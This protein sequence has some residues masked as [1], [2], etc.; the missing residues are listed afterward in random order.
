[1]QQRTWMAGLLAILAGCA[2]P[3]SPVPVRGE[4][5]H[6]DGRWVGQYHSDL[7]G[8]SGSIVFTLAAGQDTARG[9]VIMIPASRG[10]VATAPGEGW[11]SE[12]L[13]IEFVEIRNGEVS[14]RLDPYRDPE[15]GCLV[16]TVFTGRLRGEVLEG[17]FRTYHRADEHV[18]EGRWR[19]ERAGD[20]P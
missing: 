8:R 14:G 15:C 16:T 9:D 5:A 18:V 10:N 11:R 1:M 3:G 17:T 20:R 12:V 2:A 7:S 6:L 13:T 4:T 19:V